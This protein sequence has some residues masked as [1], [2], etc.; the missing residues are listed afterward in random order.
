MILRSYQYQQMACDQR[1]RS[2]LCCMKPHSDGSEQNHFLSESIF[3]TL[4]QDVIFHCVSGS[5]ETELLLTLNGKQIRLLLENELMFLMKCDVG[6]VCVSV[7]FFGHS[8]IIYAL[9]KYVVWPHYI[10]GRDVKRVY[11]H[12]DEF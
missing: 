10:Q 11:E 5:C 6:V 2:L 12:D 1:L 7:G 4:P 3:F 9:I 8:S